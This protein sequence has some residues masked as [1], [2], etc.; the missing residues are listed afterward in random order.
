MPTAATIA[1][2]AAAS[3]AILVIPGPAVLF[4]INRS[5]ADGRRIGLASVAGV[6]LG[7]LAHVVA[8]TAGLS[9]LIAASTVAFSVIKWLGVAYL[10]V[11]GIR[12][13][14]SRPDAMSVERTAVSAPHAFRQGVLVNILNPKVAL[15]FLSFL[16][17]FIDPARGAEWSQSL[18]LGTTFVLLGTCSDC[19]YALG[20][21]ALRHALVR[22]RGLPFVQRYVAGTV[23]VG[24]GILA[25]ATGQARHTS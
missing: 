3:I 14:A 11:T 10:V 4:I 8:A 18:V 17:Q 15:F 1:A 2:F 22:G 16:P 19:T 6:E 21:S 25:A 9:A 5:V 23:F 20:A 13:L 24:L 12:T 7:T